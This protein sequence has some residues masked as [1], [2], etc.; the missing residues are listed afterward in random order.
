[1]S[2]RCTQT[3]PNHTMAWA[4]AVNPDFRIT[5][6]SLWKLILETGPKNGTK[7]CIQM[8]TKGQSSL[9]GQSGDGGVYG[10][11]VGKRIEFNMDGRGRGQDSAFIERLWWIV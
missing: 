1:M 10:G 2:V 4:C 5:D 9:K 8:S 3:H 6:L 7:E 11:A